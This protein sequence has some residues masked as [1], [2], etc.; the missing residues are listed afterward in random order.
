ME[1]VQSIKDIEHNFKVLDQYLDAKVDPEYTFALELIKKG[2][3]FIGV[4]K[5]QRI[6]FYPSRFI[7]Y[8]EN[9]MDKHLENDQKD[10]RL[11]NPSISSII[12]VQPIMR[13]ELEEAYKHYCEYL[14]F[15]PNDKGSFGVERKYWFLSY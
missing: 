8:K 15:V 10:G 9:D 2:T 6:R 12:G 5:N 1:F 4:R 7:G 13:S 11:T 3:C 14:G